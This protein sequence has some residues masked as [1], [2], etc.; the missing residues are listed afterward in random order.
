MSCHGYTDA[1]RRL[2][3]TNCS[4]SGGPKNRF[5]RRKLKE[6]RYDQHTILRV[7]AEGVWD[8]K[9]SQQPGK[10][11]VEYPDR[12][13]SSLFA[14]STPSSRR[15]LE[16]GVFGWMGR[17]GGRKKAS[18]GVS[19]TGAAR[20][21]AAC[22]GQGSTREYRLSDNSTDNTSLAQSHLDK[23]THSPV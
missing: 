21:G 17:G 20:R 6:F 16:R 2:L 12:H 10:K 22:L 14:I 13:D 1:G 23:F 3:K 18:R 15:H 7:R 11:I 4:G 8:R 9:S 5:L 19:G